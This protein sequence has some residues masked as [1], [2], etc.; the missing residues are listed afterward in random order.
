VWSRCSLTAIV[1]PA[2]LVPQGIP[3][4][5]KGLKA[6]PKGSRLLSKSPHFGRVCPGQEQGWKDGTK[7]SSGRSA[8]E[9]ICHRIVQHSRPWGAGGEDSFTPWASLL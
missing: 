8:T 6:V 3:R 5:G 9:I 1:P 4:F 2:T 7:V